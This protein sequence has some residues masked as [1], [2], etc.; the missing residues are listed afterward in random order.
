MS[1]RLGFNPQAKK[2]DSGL[3][4]ELKKEFNKESNALRAEIKEENAELRKLLETQMQSTS[5]LKD[6]LVKMMAAGQDV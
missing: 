4:E 1:F 5:E 6:M 3:R 2:N